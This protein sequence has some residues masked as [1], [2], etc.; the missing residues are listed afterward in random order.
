MAYHEREVNPSAVTA[1]VGNERLLWVVAVAFFG[2][3]DLATT[4]AGLHF[5]QV[6]EV[7]PVVDDVILAYGTVAMVGLKLFV[8]A[9]GYALWRIVPAPHRAGVPLGLA[10]LGVLVTFW[11][12]GILAVVIL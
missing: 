6:A 5:E 4:W 3:G 11:N 7:G 2:I 1:L 9:V 8:F 12:V 10:V